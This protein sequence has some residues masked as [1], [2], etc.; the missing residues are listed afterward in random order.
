VR[1]ALGLPDTLSR[2]P[3]RRLAPFAWAHSRA[4]SPLFYGLWNPLHHSLQSQAGD[5]ALRPL[6][7]G[8]GSK[9]PVAPYQ[10]Q[11]SFGRFAHL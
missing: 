11:L 4:R 7:V 1:R 8:D 3:L 10:S 5:A 2:E 9:R 6:A